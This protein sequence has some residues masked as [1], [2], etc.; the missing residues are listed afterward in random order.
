[1]RDTGVGFPSPEALQQRQTFG[2]Q[3]ISA[4]AQKLKA[5]LEYYND[6]G[7]VVCMRIKKYKL[8]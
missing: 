3:L 6:N 7:A 8:A 5:Q 2:L 4:F 1:V